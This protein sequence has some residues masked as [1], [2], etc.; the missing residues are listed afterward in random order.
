MQERLER[1]LT[2]PLAV[3]NLPLRVATYV[4]QEEEGSDKVRVLVAT[5]VERDPADPEVTFGYRLVAPDGKTLASRAMGA[6]AAEGGSLVEQFAAFIVE[7]GQYRLMLAAVED[8]G[9]HG[10][11]THRFDACRMA[12]Q[13]FAM[14]DLMLTTAEAD[15]AIAARPQVVPRLTAGHLRTYLELYSDDPAELRGLR[16][17]TEV[18]RTPTGTAL[19][20]LT[21][22][23]APIE[24]ATSGTVSTVLRVDAFPLGPYVVRAAVVQDGEVLGRRWR[25]FEIEHAPAVLKGFAW[26]RAQPVAGAAAPEPLAPAAPLE[27]GCRL[28]D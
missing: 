20:S 8:E 18:A 27:T 12:D 21:N 4:Y 3:P 26:N 9:R 11:L 25:S 6:R 23:L 17:R 7:P 5:D 19:F 14:G 13:P 10:S 22:D 2:S 1:L 16:V 24:G 28:L 15:D